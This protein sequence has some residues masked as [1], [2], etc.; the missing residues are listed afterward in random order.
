MKYHAY[1][2]IALFTFC[3]LLGGDFPE[4]PENLSADNARQAKRKANRK[5][6]YKREKQKREEGPELLA[7][8]KEYHKRENQK[9]KEDPAL[10]AKHKARLREYKEKANQKRKESPALQA[11]HRAQLKAKRER[12]KQKRKAERAFEELYSFIPQQNLEK[13]ALPTQSFEEIEK[14]LKTQL[15]D[16]LNPP[17]PELYPPWDDLL[18][19]EEK[20]EL[21][22]RF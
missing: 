18:N 20:E 7:Q 4:Q 12:E 22:R 5:A 19:Y 3:N 11:K 6:R 14:E 17:Q 10:Q 21:S 8:H 16:L 9:R 15:D 1:L 2:F 13:E